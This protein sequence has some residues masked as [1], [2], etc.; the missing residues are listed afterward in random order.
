MELFDTHLNS[1]IL[2]IIADIKNKNNKKKCNRYSI[3]VI[4]SKTKYKEEAK[5]DKM[6]DHKRNLNIPSTAHVFK[7]Y[8]DIYK[9]RVPLVEQELP[10][11]PEHL[12]S[13]SVVRV[14]RIAR[15]L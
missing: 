13:P 2:N 7:R 9:R 15:S 14:V 12:H 11:L 10:T 8:I 3:T 5:T 4:H 1:N 6:S